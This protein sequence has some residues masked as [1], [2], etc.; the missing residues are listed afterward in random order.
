M[1]HGLFRSSRIYAS[2][3]ISVWIFSVARRPST[4][5]RPTPLLPLSVPHQDP[6]QVHPDIRP[7]Q[8]ITHQPMI[9]VAN[10][11]TDGL[12][13]CAPSGLN[14]PRPCDPDVGIAMVWITIRTIVLSLHSI[15]LVM[16]ADSLAISCQLVVPASS[17]PSFGTLMITPRLR[18]DFRFLSLTPMA[19]F[20]LISFVLS[21]LWECNFLDLRRSR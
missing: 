10:L 11:A 16:S 14:A 1:P 13:N 7:R 9:N 3:R 4:A 5:P 19:R 21:R 15:S 8:H 17:V 20:H 2:S 6:P 18:R 12:A